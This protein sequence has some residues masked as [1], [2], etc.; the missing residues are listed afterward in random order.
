[1]RLKAEIWIGGLLRRAQSSGAMA[2]IAHR[3]DKDAGSVMV[4][5]NALDGC[6][7]LYVP[8]TGLEGERR[9]RLL[10]GGDTPDTQVEEI[11]TREIEYDPDLWVVEIEDRQ[12]RHF[13]D[14]A[15][16]TLD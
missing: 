7:A 3:G 16:E 9:W 6:S 15:V 8:F 1:M 14:E 10:T 2:L 11:I 13:L 12:G 4:R 5:V